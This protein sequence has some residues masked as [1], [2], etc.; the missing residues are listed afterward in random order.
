VRSLRMHSSLM[1]SSSMSSSVCSSFNHY[2]SI[3]LQ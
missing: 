2:N 3:S 1:S